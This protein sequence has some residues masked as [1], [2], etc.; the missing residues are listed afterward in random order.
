MV[1]YHPPMSTLVKKAA[2]ITRGAM[3]PSQE[4]AGLISLKHVYHIAEM[5]RQVGNEEWRT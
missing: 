1:L 5:K 3:M 2:G 4:T